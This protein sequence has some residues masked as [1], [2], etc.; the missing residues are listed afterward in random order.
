MDWEADAAEALSVLKKVAPII[1]TE[2]PALKPLTPFLPLIG[3]ALQA[4]L[5]VQ[6]ATGDDAGA[7]VRAVASTL[8]PGHANAPALTAAP[9]P[10]AVTEDHVAAAGNAAA[11]GSTDAAIAALK[12]LPDAASPGTA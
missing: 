2:V 5:A 8:A 11:S 9:A 12:N 3:I 4:V 7:A 10:G 6:R 1:V